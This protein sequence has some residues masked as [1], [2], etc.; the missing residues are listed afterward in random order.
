MNQAH[1][2]YCVLY[3]YHY[4]IN[5]TSDHHIRSRRLGAPALENKDIPYQVFEI[6]SIQKYGTVP[7]LF[8]GENFA[9]KMRSPELESWTLRKFLNHSGSQFLFLLVE[10]IMFY[11]MGLGLGLGQPLVKE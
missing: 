7:D 6:L 2:M 5:T 3:I 9:L 11:L 4:Y 10:D 1:Y 8:C